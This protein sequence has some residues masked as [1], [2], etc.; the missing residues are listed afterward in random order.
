LK[1]KV[2]DFMDK[3]ENK[4]TSLNELG[5]FGLIEQIK[6]RARHIHQSTITGIG[7]DAAVI[8][9]KGCMTLVSTDLLLEGIHFNL[10]YSRLKHLGYKAVIRAISDNYAMNRDPEELLVSPGFTLP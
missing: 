7:D 3:P 4:N 9:P 1:K 8:D 5:K 10:I 2:P 6:R